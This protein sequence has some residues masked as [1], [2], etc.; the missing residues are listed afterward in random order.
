MAQRLVDTLTDMKLNYSPEGVFT[1]FM[2][3]TDNTPLTK[4]N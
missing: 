4:M 3:M 1:T 2:S